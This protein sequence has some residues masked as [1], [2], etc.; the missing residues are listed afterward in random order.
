MY[1]LSFLIGLILLL[2]GAELLVRGG[3][4]I[5]LALR[6]PVIVVALTIVAFG[7][8]MPEITVSVTAALRGSSEIALSNVI[9]SNIA[10]IALVLG[11]AALVMPLTVGR[12]L[13]R[14]EV[15]TLVLL[16]LVVPVMLWSDQTV[17]RIEGIVLVF[18]GVVYNVLL[19]RDAMRGR[20]ELT[21][22]DELE[23]GGD[24]F[25]NFALLALGLAMLVVGAQ[26]FVDGAVQIART[27]GINERIIG[28]TVVAL[29][30]S[31]P[32]VVTSLVS[33]WKGETDMAVGNALG[34]NIVNVAFALGITAIIQPVLMQD[35][36][37]WKDLAVA[38]VV[39]LLLIPMILRGRDVSRFEGLLLCV[40]YLVYL[41]MLTT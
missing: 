25:T 22:D 36:G 31:A 12:D 38:F 19:V 20:R 28:L 32:E 10:N 15:P 5:A 8:S 18:I 9:G 37:G 4:R 3:G 26:F 23:A 2:G 21:D 29:G 16:Q 13:M 39:T 14:R 27:L 33:A 40:A 7:T 6:V 30:T 1:L 34:S 11:S 24:M 41:L 35:T 17:G